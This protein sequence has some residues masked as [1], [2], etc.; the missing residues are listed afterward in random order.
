MNVRQARSRVSAI[1]TMLAEGR[2]DR[3]TLVA[4][5]MRIQSVLSMAVGKH[6]DTPL[7][8][9]GD[10]SVQEAPAA[11]PARAS[12]PIR[13]TRPPRP[14]PSPAGPLCPFCGASAYGQACPN[15][16][17]DWPHPPEVRI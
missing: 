6:A 9:L 17:P 1:D 13:V 8:V 5:K 2:G 15:D 4:E 7:S 14:Q 10:G 11:A 16:G 12:A 3:R